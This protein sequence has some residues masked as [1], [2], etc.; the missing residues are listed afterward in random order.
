M[1]QIYYANLIFKCGGKGFV[2]LAGSVTAFG[3]RLE[4]TFPKT[5]RTLLCAN[6]TIVRDGSESDNEFEKR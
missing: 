6:V 5:D 2:S 3:Y 4:I 1:R